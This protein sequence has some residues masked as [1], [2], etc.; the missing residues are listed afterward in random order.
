MIPHAAVLFD[1]DGTLIDSFAAIAAS[2]NHVRQR[3]GL[4]SLPEAEVSKHVGRGAI[5][6]L[7]DVVPTGDLQEN[8]AWYHQHHP[9]VLRTLTR[10]LPGAAETL[11][12]LDAVGKKLGICSNKPVNFSRELVEH[13]GIARYLDAVL[14]PEDVARP[15]PAPDMLHEAMRRLGSQPANTLYVGD[16]TIDI[17]TARAAGVPI[18]VIATGIQP[19]VELQGADRLLT[20]LEELVGR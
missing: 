11:E 6:L 20:R 9:T 15:K 10:L 14:G 13:L 16:M 8:L 17:E 1:L 4:C 7:Q 19:A 5:R 12:Q 2:V 18:W 3:R